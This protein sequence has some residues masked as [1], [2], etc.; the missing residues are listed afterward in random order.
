MNHHRLTAA[1]VFVNVTPESIG[2]AT[3]SAAEQA[4]MTTNQ[5]SASIEDISNDVNWLLDFQFSTYQPEWEIPGLNQTNIPIR[6]V[7]LV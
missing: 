4:Q 6:T 3:Y 1:G 5:N 7:P 2:A